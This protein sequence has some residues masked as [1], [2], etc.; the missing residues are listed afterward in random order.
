MKLCNTL[1]NIAFVLAKD[2]IDTKS[3]LMSNGF[4]FLVG[5]AVGLVFCEHMF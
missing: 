4:S 2:Q 3:M 5:I 1:H